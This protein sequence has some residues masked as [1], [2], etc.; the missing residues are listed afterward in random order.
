VSLHLF[1]LDVALVF[2]VEESEGSKDGLRLI[3]FELLVFE[4]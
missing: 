2:G 3:G 1:D 4:N